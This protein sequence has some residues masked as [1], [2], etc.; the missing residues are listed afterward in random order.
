MSDTTKAVIVAV[1]IGGLLYW[2]YVSSSTAPVNAPN[3]AG[4]LGAAG[5]ANATTQGLPQS[6]ST[7]PVVGDPTGNPSPGPTAGTILA[8][9]G[10]AA[11][12]V[13][14]TNT[15]PVDPNTYVTNL[16][17]RVPSL[18]G[19]DAYTVNPTTGYV[20]PTSTAAAQANRAKTGAGAAGT[21]STG[22]HAA[23][24]AAAVPAGY[25]AAP[26][27]TVTYPTGGGALYTSKV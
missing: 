2:Y 5:A 9:L 24:A 17:K 23:P 6:G 20:S 25:H 3:G 8:G 4:S 13:T 21:S 1:G 19:T 10:Y 27:A 7:N 11:P 14:A 22:Y 26:A 18:A 12:K 16:L 15:K